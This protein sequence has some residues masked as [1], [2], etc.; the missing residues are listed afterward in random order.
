MALR[1]PRAVPLKLYSPLAWTLIGGL[2][3]AAP[4]VALA[5]KKA[6]PP[7]AEEQPSGLSLE[8]VA[9]MLSSSNPDEVKMAIESSAM[10]GNPDVVPM[11]SERVR[12]GLPSDLLNSAIDALGL[13]NAPS[14]SDLFVMLTRHRRPSV[15]VRSVQALIAL[16]TKD[17]EP[18]IVLALGDSAPE[19]REAAAEGLGQLGATGSVEPLFQAFDRG[20]VSAGRSIGKLVR[21][22]QVQRLLDLVGR[23]PLT[24]LTP[25]FDAIFA[26]GDISEATKLSIVTALAELGTAESRGYLEGLKTKL[27]DAP[28]RLRKA[29]DDSVTRIAK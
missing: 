28:P 29:I 11:L 22:D 17:A 25:V 19:V 26:R 27:P 2:S 4:G 5:K 10:L 15:R 6:P 20:V 23:M 1:V 18:A 24:G 8:E 21:D 9:V 7:P 3:A 16:R 12:A 13:L 14:S